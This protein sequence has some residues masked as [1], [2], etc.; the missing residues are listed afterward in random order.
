MK[1][2]PRKTLL[3][4]NYS[5]LLLFLSIA[6]FPKAQL[7]Q[8]YSDMVSTSNDIHKISFYTPAQGY[9][10][11][12]DAS[13]DWVGYTADSGRTFIKR[14]ITLANVDYNG[15]GVNLTFGFG[16]AGVKA[17]DQNNILV[18]GDYGL[19]PAILK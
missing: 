10:A 12:T 8:I 18:Y 15:Y 5:L 4:K 17:F 6:F 3:K 14:P 1:V 2:S 9:V 16:I 13:W 19:V 7:R 11:S